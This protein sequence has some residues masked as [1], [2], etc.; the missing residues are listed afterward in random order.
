MPTLLHAYALDIGSDLL[1]LAGGD[2][3]LKSGVLIVN[4]LFEGVVD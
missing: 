4:G 2:F 1:T 3:L